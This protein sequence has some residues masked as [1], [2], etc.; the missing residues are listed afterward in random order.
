MLSSDSARVGRTPEVSQAA[1]WSLEGA[2]K[3]QPSKQQDPQLCAGDSDSDNVGGGEDG[4]RTAGVWPGLGEQQGTRRKRKVS[5]V[6]LEHALVAGSTAVSGGKAT[7][8][9]A[10]VRRRVG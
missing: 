8:S 2:G 10:H 6:R 4:K 1:R 3:A 7:L 9:H 5:K